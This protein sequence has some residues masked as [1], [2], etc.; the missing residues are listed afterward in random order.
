M[1]SSAALIAA[2]VPVN[3]IV[4]SFAPLPTVKT[5]PAVP[6]SVSVPLVAVSVTS[7]G[8]TPAS[9]SL[10]AIR[11]PEPVEKTSATSSAEI[12]AAG[13]MFTGGSLARLA[14][15]TVTVAVEV[16]PSASRMV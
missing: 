16:S 2:W 15:V 12:C 4:A 8:F 11:L 10:T 6:A 5:S 7:S 1:P 13:T 14:T 3:V 9:G